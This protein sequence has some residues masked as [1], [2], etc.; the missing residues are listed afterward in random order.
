RR[1]HTRSY[2]DW[3]SD[4]CSSDLMRPRDQFGSSQKPASEL[5]QALVARGLAGASLEA[6]LRQSTAHNMILA[7]NVRTFSR[8]ALARNGDK[9]H[10]SQARS[11]KAEV[12]H[13]GK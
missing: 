1:R 2:G 9:T 12:N 11:K 5:I 3:S 10:R 13:G 8:R 6:R 7:I 4:V